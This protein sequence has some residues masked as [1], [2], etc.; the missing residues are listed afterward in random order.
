MEHQFV[1]LFAF[2]L[3]AAPAFSEIN[4]GMDG[5]SFLEQVKPAPE[6]W[7]PVEIIAK[8]PIRDDPGKTRDVGN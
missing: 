3:I 5:R 4:A 1:G 2:R 8:T 6:I 7:K